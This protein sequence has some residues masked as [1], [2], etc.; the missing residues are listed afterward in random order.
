MQEDYTSLEG[1]NEIIFDSL[2][3]T[4]LLVTMRL[5]VMLYRT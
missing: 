2:V 5:P 1:A 3:I 4:A